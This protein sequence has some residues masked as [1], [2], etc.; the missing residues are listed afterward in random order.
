MLDFR[1]LNSLWASILVETL[2]R[3][4]LTCAVIC[5]GSRSAPL[6]TAFAQHPQIE[7]IPMLDERSASFFAL[8]Q[9][10]RTHRPVA[11]ICTS[12][13]AAA[14][15]YA[16]VIEARENQVPLL[17]LSADRPPELRD[18]NAGQAIDQQHLF[19][20]Y[21]NAYYEF[22]LP[23][24]E[25]L[26]YLR[27]RLVQAY[28]QTRYPVAGVVHLNLP[29]RDP[30]A[31]LPQPEIQALAASF[32]TDFFDHIGTAAIPRNPSTSPHSHG[33]LTALLHHWQTRRG[34]MVAGVDRALDPAGYCRTIAQLSKTLGYPVLAEGLSPLRNWASLQPY[35]VST[36]DWILRSSREA[37]VPEVVI[38]I[39]GMPTSKVLRAWLQQTQPATWV[40]DASGRSRDPLHGKTIHLPWDL[41]ALSTAL[42]D[43][44]SSWQEGAALLPGSD[45]RQQWLSA[46]AQARQHINA[47]LAQQS[48]LCEPK[49]AWLLSHTLPAHT[50]LVI[51]N[52]MPVRDVEWFWQPNDAGIVPFCNRGANGIDGTLSTALGVAHGGAPTVLLTGDLALL[53][54]T[55]GALIRPYFRGSLT[56]VLINNNGG[57]IFEMLPIA[58]FDPPFE[59]FFATPQPVTFADWCRTYGLEHQ[60]VQSWQHLASCLHSLPQQGIR[61]LEVQTDRRRDAQW[62]QQ[63]WP[64]SQS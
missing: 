59:A 15:F 28:Q 20:Y 57:G 12:G 61:V 52:S 29:L 60:L 37:L 24:V 44:A 5:P 19:G 64:L 8:G 21:P 53:H 38:R 43:V 46:E 36:Y 41:S 23:Q 45:Y 51:A 18:C 25:L 7:A 31:P 54:D 26:P 50:P 34:V 17:I 39:G 27:Q 40:L 14:H 56:I 55:N 42:A 49:V 33:D 2:H 6:A 58:Q 4:G 63:Q 32:P 11:L 47:I 9:A 62:R 30:L 35:L 22:A 13:T 48:Q 10:Q 1:N 3:C 16:A